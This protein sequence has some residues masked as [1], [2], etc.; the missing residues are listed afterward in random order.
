MLNDEGVIKYRQ[1]NF[2]QIDKLLTI[3]YHKLEIWREKLFKLGLIGEYPTSK[4]GYGNLSLAQD[5]SKFHQSQERQFV[6][7]GTQ[8]GALAQLTG[9][10]YTRV[11]DYDLENFEIHIMGPIPASSEALTHAAFYRV[12]SK[13]QAVFHIHHPLIWREL[14]KDEETRIP[15][16]EYGTSQMAMMAAE[17]AIKKS[18]G[19]FAMSGHEEGVI[20]YAENMERAGNLILEA[21]QKFVG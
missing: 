9:K 5:Y 7:T 17:H 8:T 6:V 15:P 2:I 16:V 18:E 1:K 13:I 11:L 12:N 14:L 10:H 3:E 19:I 4:V 20:A 21:Y